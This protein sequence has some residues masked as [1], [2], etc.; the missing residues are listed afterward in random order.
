MSQR[1]RR[2]DA[3]LKALNA[4]SEKAEISG[5]LDDHGKL[6]D[7]DMIGYNRLRDTDAVDAALWTVIDDD[8]FADQ[9]ALYDIFAPVLEERLAVE[10]A[11][12][13][14]NISDASIYVGKNLVAHAEALGLDLTEYERLSADGKDAVNEA[15]FDDIPF[16]DE[17]EIETAFDAA[18]EDE[19]ED[20]AVAAV[21]SATA[22]K[23]GGV[24]E[25]YFDIFDIEI[26]EDSDYGKLT[27][28][29]QGN[30]H[31]A[32]VGKDFAD[33]AAVKSAFEQAVTAQQAE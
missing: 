5:I 28:E 8:G 32:L 29:K 16:A 25:L 24:L 18:V 12:D 23:M 31:T 13:A 21:N 30:V 20:E 9:L 6:L 27:T 17:D 22:A 10:A 33:A 11:V 15:L 14:I 3:G 19:L 26:D 4:A 7:L 2:W 1:T